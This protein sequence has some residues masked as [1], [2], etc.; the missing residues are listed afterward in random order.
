[1]VLVFYRPKK[2]FFFPSFCFYGWNFWGLWGIVFGNSWLSWFDVVRILINLKLSMSL[3]AIEDKLWINI[4]ILTCIIFLHILWIFFKKNKIFS[5]QFLECDGV[6]KIYSGILVQSWLET[7]Y[8]LGCHGSYTLYI[9][10]LHT[11]CS[12]QQLHA[13]I[14]K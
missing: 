3:R 4:Y 9:T 6:W 12:C 8:W 10:F 14:Q 13:L 7:I 11:C 5:K 1:M 2:E